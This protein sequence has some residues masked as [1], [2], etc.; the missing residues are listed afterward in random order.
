MI[1]KSILLLCILSCNT[2]AV[3]AVETEIP[4]ESTQPREISV[5]IE[6][7]KELENTPT[8]SSEEP[9]PPLQ[10]MQTACPCALKKSADETDSLPEEPI[11]ASEELNEELA[12]IPE[13]ESET[14]EPATE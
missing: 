6:D 10:D 9:T 5:L 3:Y 11:L 1:K 7:P 12:S 13:E 4:T 14:E 8:S 2:P